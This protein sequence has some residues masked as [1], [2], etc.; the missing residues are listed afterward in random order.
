MGSVVGVVVEV[1]V[2]AMVIEKALETMTVVLIQ[3][4][5]RK[6]EMAVMIMQARL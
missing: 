5:A 3:S 4:M 6:L 1:V 2:S